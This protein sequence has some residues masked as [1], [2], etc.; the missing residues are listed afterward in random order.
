MESGGGGGDLAGLSWGGEL[1]GQG[2]RS[3]AWIVPEP[4][5]LRVRSG[6]TESERREESTNRWARIREGT[7]TARAGCAR[8]L[9]RRLGVRRGSPV[10][11]QG[12]ALSSGV[13]QSKIHLGSGPPED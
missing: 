13:P 1:S 11:E 3:G 8:D 12:A 5:L 2:D 9:W 10:R 6:W 7:R 4:P